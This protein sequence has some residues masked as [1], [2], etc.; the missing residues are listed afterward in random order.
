MNKTLSKIAF[1]FVPA[2][3][4]LLVYLYILIVI[5][6]ELIFHHA[7]PAFI[8]SSFFA[9]PFLKYPGGLSELVANFIM[10]KNLTSFLKL[11]EKYN[12]KNIEVRLIQ[13]SYMNGIGLMKAHNPIYIVKGEK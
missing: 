13:A 9:Y 12:Y 3:F 5:Q 1:T 6:P 4:L 2:S 11:L 7:Q 8:S 10:P